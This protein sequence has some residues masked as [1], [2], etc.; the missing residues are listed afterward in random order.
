MNRVCTSNPKTTK[1]ATSVAREKCSQASRTWTE[2]MATDSSEKQENILPRSHLNYKG[3][4][5]KS[6]A[7]WNMGGSMERLYLT[8]FHTHWKKWKSISRLGRRRNWFFKDGKCG[9][10]C[11]RRELRWLSAK[12]FTHIGRDRVNLINTMW[13]LAQGKA[14]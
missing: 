12:G 5:S 7:N 10:F 8:Q 4:P 2:E 11:N 9:H 13:I 6:D 1:S 14:S 3:H